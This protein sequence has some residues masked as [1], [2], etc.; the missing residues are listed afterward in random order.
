MWLRRVGRRL[1]IAWFDL[2][3]LH[4]TGSI[5]VDG[6]GYG[7]E[8]DK[9]ENEDSRDEGRRSLCFVFVKC[10]SEFNSFVRQANITSSC[11][12]SPSTISPRKV[13]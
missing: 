6:G 12:A 1:G 5:N 13:F 3:R 9:F 11:T 2:M 7:P 8:K 10:S 4:V